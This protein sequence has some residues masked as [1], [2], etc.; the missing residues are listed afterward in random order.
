MPVVIGQAK[1]VLCFLAS[2]VRS[3]LMVVSLPLGTFLISASTSSG[4]GMTNRPSPNFL[5][6]LSLLLS[7]YLG[8]SLV[9]L[10][11][12]VQLTLVLLAAMRA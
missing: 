1:S 9:L 7:K 3:S 5:E 12:A 2:A 4:A 6:N 10:S 8:K 11:L